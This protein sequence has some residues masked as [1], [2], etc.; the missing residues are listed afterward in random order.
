MR[1]WV[2]LCWIENQ[3]LSIYM[4]QWFFIKFSLVFK[5]KSKGKQYPKYENYANFYQLHVRKRVK[6]VSNGQK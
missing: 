3:S 1:N 4:Y 2:K 5:A 6:L